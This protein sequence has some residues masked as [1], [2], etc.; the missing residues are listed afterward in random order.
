MLAN[1]SIFITHYLYRKIVYID[2]VEPAESDQR[3]VD[4]VEQNK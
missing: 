1:P 2:C 3:K 4:P